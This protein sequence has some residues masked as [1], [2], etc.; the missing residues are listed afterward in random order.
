MNDS[1]S[2]YH[3]TAFPSGEWT[4]LPGN[5]VVTGKKNSRMAGKIYRDRDGSLVRPAQ[6]SKSDYGQRVV[7]NRIETLSSEEYRETPLNTVYPEKKLRAVCT[8]TWNPCGP[9]VFRD[10]K[11][12]FFDPLWRLNKGIDI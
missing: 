4:P 10:I 2:V 3:S 11:K 7:L 8:H 1:L 9:Y 12:R 6:Y 5:P